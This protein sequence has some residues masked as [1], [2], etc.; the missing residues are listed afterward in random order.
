[1]ALPKKPLKASLSWAAP[2]LFG[3][4]IK[5]RLR[6][7]IFC[8]VSL[9]ALGVRGWGKEVRIKPFF[10]FGVSIPWD[11]VGVAKP[12]GVDWRKRHNI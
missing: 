6:L 12:E 2:G 9:I 11:D 10:D 5:R 4:E 3:Q 8:F 1:V 7:V